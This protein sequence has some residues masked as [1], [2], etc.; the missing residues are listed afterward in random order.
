MALS[1]P[2]AD[3]PAAE[4]PVRTLPSPRPACRTV[5]VTH[6]AVRLGQKHLYRLGL[7]GDGGNA[8]GG[9]A[10]GGRFELLPW[11]AVIPE[12]VADSAVRLVQ[13]SS[14]LVAIRETAAMPPPVFALP[15]RGAGGHAGGTQRDAAADGPVAAR[16]LAGH[17]AARQAERHR[18]IGSRL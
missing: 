11:G 4:A 10:R 18:P 15:R 2:L 14:M 3:A 9:A 6:R 5:G 7:A 17:E 16:G 8:A 12:G 13:N 1:L